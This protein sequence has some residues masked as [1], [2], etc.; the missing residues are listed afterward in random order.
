MHICSQILSSLPKSRSISMYF[1]Y[2]GRGEKFCINHL[3]IEATAK[4]CSFPPKIS[5][6]V[7]NAFKFLLSIV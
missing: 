7:G 5:Q 6:Q 3:K 2:Q 4:I 1:S